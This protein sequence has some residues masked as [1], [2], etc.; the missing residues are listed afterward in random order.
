[1][2]SC[3]DLPTTRPWPSKSEFTRRRLQRH[4]RLVQAAH[5]GVY[6][7]QWG[8]GKGTSWHSR[9]KRL[10]ELHGGLGR[11]ATRWMEMKARDDNRIAARRLPA[12]RRSDIRAK[13]APRTPA[14]D[15]PGRCAARRI[16]RDL[17]L[18][19]PPPSQARNRCKDVQVLRRRTILR[20]CHLL[21]VRSLPPLQPALR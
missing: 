16:S 14:L 10:E 5:G 7:G 3:Q 18:T 2:D 20:L 11:A 1:M 9:L 19:A 8:D 12:A 13:P 15:D 6:N 4:V 21:W 17:Q